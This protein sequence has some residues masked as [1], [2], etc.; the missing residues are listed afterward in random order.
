MENNGQQLMDDQDVFHGFVTGWTAVHLP[1]LEETL[2]EIGFDRPSS[3]ETLLEC[4]AGI[5]HFEMTLRYQK[6][7]VGTLELEYRSKTTH[8]LCADITISGTL[9]LCHREGL[10]TGTEYIK[11]LPEKWQKML[12]RLKNNKLIIR[13]AI[14]EA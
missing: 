14:F 2:E 8:W 5:T 3:R 10:R 6:E 1:T 4:D 9:I 12:E 13:R 11:V 7:A